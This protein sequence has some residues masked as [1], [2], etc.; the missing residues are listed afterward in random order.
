MPFPDVAPRGDKRTIRFREVERSRLEE[1]VAAGL[2]ARYF[3]PHRLHYLPKCGPDA[4]RLGRQMCGEHQA[5]GH[6][7]VLLHA[8]ASLIE[9]FPASLFF[10]DD[11]IWH[12]QHFGMPGHIGFAYVVIARG[13]LYG[14]NYVSDLVQRVSRKRA[15]KTHVEHVF[16]GWY[17]LLLN[18]ILNFAVERRL[19]RVYSP[20]AALVMR[21]TDPERS[22]QPEL[23]ERIYDRAV[24][25]RWAAMKEG[26]WWVIDV[27]ANRNRI[28][29]PSCREQVVASAKT[30]CVSH[31][32]ER[33]I[34][35]QDIDRG[36]AEIGE[37][38]AARALTETLACEEAVGIKTTYN[39]VGRF[40]AEVRAPIERA[41]HCV[42]FHSYNHRVRPWWPV[43]RHY[44]RLRR[45]V[46]SFSEVKSKNDHEDQLY[47]CR[48][49]DGR[50]RGFRPPQS[51]PSPEW[52]DYRLTFRNFDWCATSAQG[53]GTTTPILQNQLVKIP[54]HFDEFSLYKAGESFD[55]WER[56]ALAT[57][58]R[59]DFTVFGLHDCYADLWL[60]KYPSFLK[61]IMDLGTFTTLDDVA[62]AVL[63][64]HAA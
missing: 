20:T 55:E 25:Q 24:S 57:I 3:F 1:F 4:L 32:I 36:R 52:S 29:V 40:L 19:P 56:R 63:L 64:A 2:P 35:H 15:L 34:G 43:T 46:A 37:R 7:E 8:D 44:H 51:R 26:D 6:W 50:V 14:L 21:Q 17:H 41:G 9:E 54:I 10:D 48:L 23:F 27:E 12:R 38:I 60:S 28:V 42:A 61:R 13:N 30:I 5:D 33:G 49:V 47:S 16:K 11:I 45:A 22:V 58:E 62:N 18:G 59:S 31:D 39:V 53:L